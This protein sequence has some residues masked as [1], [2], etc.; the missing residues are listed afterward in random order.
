M[1]QPPIRADLGR[2]ETPEERAERKAQ[3]SRNYRE[4]KTPNN[5]VIA[6]VAS[7]AVVLFLVLVVVRPT[8]AP[9]DPIDYVAVAAEA[10]PGVSTTLI[11][12]ALPPEWRANDAKLT[13]ARGDSFLWYIGF[14]TPKNQFL[15]LEQGIDAEAG[16]REDFLGRASPTGQVTIEGIDWDVY[17]QRETDDPGNFAYSLATS[18]AGTEYLVHGTASDNEFALFA[19]ALSAEITTPE[20]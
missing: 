17:D 20:G 8:P 14:V 16:W 6:L 11:T 15:A 2:P 4:S 5:L 9:A 7:L 3:N 1:A 12:P 19:S 10:Q 18:V 13:A